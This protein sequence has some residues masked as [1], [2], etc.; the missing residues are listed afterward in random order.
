MKM[1]AFSLRAFENYQKKCSGN[2]FRPSP[3]YGLVF[4]NG[5]SL[6]EHGNEQRRRAAGGLSQGEKRLKAVLQWRGTKAVA[7]LYNLSFGGK[8]LVLGCG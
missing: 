7:S 5:N 6:A 2:V 1:F 4:R 8:K 3:T